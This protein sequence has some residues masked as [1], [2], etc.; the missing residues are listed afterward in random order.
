MRKP[1][2]GSAPCGRVSD[3]GQTIQT[4]DKV[5]AAY[6]AQ[7]SG[8]VWRVHEHVTLQG[9]APLL[10]PP[11]G[12]V[13]DAGAGS[14]TYALAFLGRGDR[15]TLLDPS[16]G[17]L[18][19]AR[20]KVAQ[21]GLSGKA[22]FLQ[23]VVERL[24][25]REGSFDLVFCEGDAL[26]YAGPQ[27][28]AA[29]REILRVLRP[30]GAFYVSVDNR[31][32]ATLGFLAQGRVAEG[33]A[34]AAHGKGLDPYGM[35]VHAF[36]PDELRDLFVEAGAQDVRVGGKVLFAHFLPPAALEHMGRDPV[37]W[38]ELLALESR[39]SADLSLS[40]HAGHLVVTGRKGG[41]P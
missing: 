32:I 26:S 8:P 6:D 31:W 3:G 19:V 23:G 1:H 27:R 10:P 15:V 35:G 13:L 36:A 20:A 14:G 18:D 4:Y 40:G 37:A 2:D 5:A 22:R 25:L 11:G 21:R 34:A 39:L 29:A 33:F 41:A 12:A 16:P 30:G 17:M 24:S 28:A 7:N 38:G 9:V